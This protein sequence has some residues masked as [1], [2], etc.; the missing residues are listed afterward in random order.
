M[1][2]TDLARKLLDFYLALGVDEAMGDEPLDRRRAE[3]PPLAVRPPESRPV[4]SNPEPLS[5]P[6]AA[7]P[8]LDLAAL[9]PDRGLAD[10]RSLAA[11]C[12]SIAAL[13][14]AIRSFD[15]CAL[16]Q[17]AMS[18]VVY[19]GAID[20]PLLVIG[21]APGGEE[22]RLGKPFVGPAGQML[23]KMLAA[24]GLDRSRVCITNMVFWR[25]PGNRKPT[26]AELALCLPFVERFL[27]LMNPK[28]VLLAGG[29]PAQTLLGRTDGIT[30]L[31][32]RWFDWT[33]S[34]G[35]TIPMLPSYHPSY[36]LRSPGQKRDA[37]R[38]FLI[39]ADR[40]E[41]LIQS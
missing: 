28:V 10:A 40:L 27:F 11:G 13:E 38:D 37:W 17:T 15:G 4:R 31:R 6:R 7:A 8:P 24:I 33:D 30:K 20:A 39:L 19:D 34:R 26:D 14:A 5:A 25:P 16:K 29:T 1:L 12:T 35:A 3:P 21:E 23:D 22:D 32:G 9:S 2:E 36:L 18:T 41:T